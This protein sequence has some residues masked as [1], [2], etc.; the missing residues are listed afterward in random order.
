MTHPEAG[1]ANQIHISG[2]FEWYIGFIVAAALDHAI[3][4]L[5]RGQIQALKVLK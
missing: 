2:T 4:L 1:C 3:E 5:L